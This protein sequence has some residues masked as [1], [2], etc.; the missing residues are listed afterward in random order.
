MRLDE[1]SP[2]N[3]GVLAFI[4]SARGDHPAIAP[5]DS[6]ADPYSGQGSH[7]DVVERIWDELGKALPADCRCLVLGTP[8]LVH[9]T[10]AVESEQCAAVYA[11]L[12]RAGGSAP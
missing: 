1:S 2:A 11:E 12:D 10:A 7:P 5:P 6:V 4:R 8:A 9:P 3:S